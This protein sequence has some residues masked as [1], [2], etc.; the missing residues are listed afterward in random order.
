[1]VAALCV[2]RQ[3]LRMPVRSARARVRVTRLH[4][5][6]GGRTANRMHA[7]LKRH[8]NNKACVHNIETTDSSI[9]GRRYSYDRPRT[10]ACMSN[11]EQC[12]CS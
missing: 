4:V 2:D 10:H 6:Y 9:V 7:M 5:A 1:M 12:T 8:E 3:P 11:N